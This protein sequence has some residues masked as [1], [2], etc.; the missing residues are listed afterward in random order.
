M[1]TLLLTALLLV[2]AQSNAKDLIDYAIE[3]DYITVGNLLKI[4]IDP[5][6]ERDNLT[7]LLA[8]AEY[9]KDLP[10]RMDSYPYTRCF[11]VILRLLSN[12]NYQNDTGD[13]FMIKFASNIDIYSFCDSYFSKTKPCNYFRED[14]IRLQPAKFNPEITNVY[15]NNFFHMAMDSAKKHHIANEC[16]QS[17]I[18]GKCKKLSFIVFLKSLVRHAGTDINDYS[19]LVRILNT[20]NYLGHTPAMVYPDYYAWSAIGI[21]APNLVDNEG[22]TA[23]VYALEGDSN[24]KSKMIAMLIEQDLDLEQILFD[25]RTQGEWIEAFYKEQ[26]KLAHSSNFAY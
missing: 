18:D 12:L 7:P 21:L 17:K 10:E 6:M 20:Q 9:C 5:N 3:G 25:G 16:N 23:L 19:N 24:F 11:G 13:T 4:G 14:L 22:K 15:G 8:A 26:Y 2:S 1:K